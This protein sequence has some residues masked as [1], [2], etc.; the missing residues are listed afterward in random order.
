MSTFTHPKMDGIL[1]T[2][3]SASC[4]GQPV[5]VIDGEAYGPCDY[6]PAKEQAPPD[7]LITHVFG[8]KHTRT[9][10]AMHVLRA[11]ESDRPYRPSWLTSS[12]EEMAPKRPELAARFIDLW[13]AAGA[14]APEIDA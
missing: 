13:H 10:A 12:D 5:L 4:Y 8:Y 2:E 3:H 9:I 7:D 14:P 6:L 1:T 11:V